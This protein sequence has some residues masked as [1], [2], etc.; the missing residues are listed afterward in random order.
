MVFHPGTGGASGLSSGAGDGEEG[1]GAGFG[2]EPGSR[3]PR[4]QFPLLHLCTGCSSLL[5]LLFPLLSCL[6][7]SL[8]WKITS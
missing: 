6:L 5:N 8:G 7:L 4:T 2:G 3:Q 1:L